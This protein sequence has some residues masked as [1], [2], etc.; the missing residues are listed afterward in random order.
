MSM[1]AGAGAL[2]VT[3]SVHA[4]VI[5]QYFP[6]LG[7]GVGG[8]DKELTRQQ[9]LSAYQAPG[10]TLGGFR[11]D[12]EAGEA[13]GFDNNVDALPGGARSA[14]IDT[15]GSLDLHSRWSRHQLNAA[16]SVDDTRFPS[17][18]AQDRTT[19]TAQAG[20]IVDFGHDRL[21]VTYSHLSLVQMPTD[22]GAAASLQRIP[23]QVDQG[24]L[25]YT[26]ATHTRWTLIPGVDLRHFSF[27]DTNLPAGTPVVGGL[28]LNDQGYRDRLVGEES[29]AARYAL[30]DHDALVIVGRGTQIRY[31]HDLPGI[32]GRDSNGFA[33]LAGID[34]Q[35]AGTFEGRALV[36]YQ[37]RDFSNSAYATIRAPIAQVEV[38]WLPSRLTTVSASITNGI[39]DGAFESVVGFTATTASLRVQHEYARNIILS[40][41]VDVQKGS[42]PATPAVLAGTVLT[43]PRTDQKSYG[44]GIDASWLV[45]R[46]L[47]LEGAYTATNQNAID[48]T[49]FTTHMVLIRLRC[50]L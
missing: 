14:L 27:S 32:P 16:F 41:H 43:Q 11:L 31:D 1:L 42:Y 28:R 20:G 40:A 30:N 2:C 49:R 44:G 8:W 3:H 6:A 34:M 25:S 23:Y 9:A 12:G 45:N 17:R 5:G 4:Q 7:S 22:L 48:T 50:L 37:E 24:A 38:A 47:R 13:V 15:S 21:G 26:A 29:L 18:S 19:W 39:E 35:G 46:H 10:L 33:V 36:G